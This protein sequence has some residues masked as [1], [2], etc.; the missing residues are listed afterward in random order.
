MVADAGL[1]VASFDRE[2][3][4]AFDFWAIVAGEGLAVVDERERARCRRWL[5][6]HGYEV[7]TLDC[8]R[9]VD[10]LVLDLGRLFAWEAQFGYVL[11]GEHRNLNALRDGFDFDVPA[12][13]GLVLELNRPDLA[14]RAEPEWVRGLLAI[15]QE[16]SLRQLALGRRFFTVL[17]LPEGS[18][19]VGETLGTRS[20][21]WYCDLF[22]D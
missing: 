14:F 20:V 4:R 16:A 2:D 18:P 19:L 22:R 13:G 11:T 12:V 10:Q 21:P 15:A 9:G 8:D 1:S 6:S 7:K 3:W 5:E 17:V